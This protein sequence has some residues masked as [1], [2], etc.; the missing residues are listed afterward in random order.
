MNEI[1]KSIPIWQYLLSMF[2][3]FG[4]LVL[5]ISSMR[6]HY[7]FANYFWIA[8]LFT[9]PLWLMGGVVGWFR[10]AKILSV[11]IPTIIVGFARVANNESKPNKFY[12]LFKG[13]WVIRFFYGILFLNILEAT[14]KD[15]ALGNYSNAICGAILCLTIPLPLKYWEMSKDKT[16]DLLAYTTIFWNALY[17]T[18]NMCFVYGESPNYF[19]A[20]LCILLAAEIYPLIKKR[21]ELYIMSRVYTLAAHLL[22]R[23]IFP[24]LLLSMM[25]STI[26]YNENIKVLWGIINVSFGV[27]Y[28]ILFMKK[29]SITKPREVIV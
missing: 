12:S 13:Q 9:F 22:I 4:F 7:K 27:I 24:T 20:S 5:L 15:L 28:L 17:T 18:W 8:S 1:V 11:I 14:L 26:W 23:A 29:S 2:S 3:Y 19:S 21:P 10:W 16:G 25:D 6:K